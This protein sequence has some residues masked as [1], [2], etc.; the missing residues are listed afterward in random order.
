MAEISIE[1]FEILEGEIPK[2]IYNLVVE[3]AL[4]HKSELKTNWKLLMLDQQPKSIKP[5]V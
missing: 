5:L 2:R 4:E 1:S 3:W